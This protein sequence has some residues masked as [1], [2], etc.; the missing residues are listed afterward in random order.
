MPFPTETY[1]TLTT[2]RLILREVV[3]EDADDVFAFRSDR[4]VQ[5]YNIEP[6]RS[7]TDALSLVRTMRSW[8]VTQYAIQ[9]GIT[10]KDENR[11]LGLCGIHEWSR[12]QRRAM[13]GYDLARAYWGQGIAGEAMREVLRFSFEEL[14]LD[15]IEATTI[16][17]NVRSIR[18]L[19][20]LGFALAGVRPDHVYARDGRFHSSA[21]YG[22]LR[23]EYEPYRSRQPADCAGP[24]ANT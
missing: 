12:E 16:V 20:R 15:R 22:L 17:E 13:V 2:E 3:A 19:E 1:P 6:M 9:W 23:C 18:L 4:E 5:K 11:V 8:Y 24:G 10:L 21:V 7:R 14:E